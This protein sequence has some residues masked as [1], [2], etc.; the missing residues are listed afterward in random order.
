MKN[1]ILLIP[2][3]LATSCATIFTGTKDTIVFNSDP[4]GA[5]I[6]IDGLEVCKTPCTTKLKR[7]LSD[8]IAEIK[9]L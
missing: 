1:I 2:I 4:S 8:K 7:S 5:K 6:F 9:W 3:L